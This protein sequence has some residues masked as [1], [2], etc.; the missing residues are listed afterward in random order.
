V[1]SPPASTAEPQVT[2]ANALEG[3]GHHFDP[4]DAVAA[5][6]ENFSPPQLDTSLATEAHQ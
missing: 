1:T 2:V 4:T 5:T 6:R 3:P